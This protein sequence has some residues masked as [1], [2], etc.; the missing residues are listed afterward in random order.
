MF[1]PMFTKNN[2][3]YIDI[4]SIHGSLLCSLC[5]Y[6]F[7]NPVLTKCEPK[8]HMFCHQCI[9]QRIKLDPACPE[10][11]CQQ[12][13]H[14][15]YLTSDTHVNFSNMLDDL[16]VRCLGCEET[17]LKRCDFEAHYNGICP[18]INGACPAADMGCSQRGTSNELD[19]HLKRCIIS[20]VKPTFR[21]FQKYTEESID[22]IKE[23][24]N[25]LET[26]RIDKKQLGKNP[27]TRISSIGPEKADH[28]LNIK[29]NNLQGTI[30]SKIVALL[31]IAK[32]MNME[33]ILNTLDEYPNQFVM[34]PKYD[35]QEEVDNTALQNFIK[36]P[37][38]QLQQSKKN[39]TNDSQSTY[40]K[41]NL[42]NHRMR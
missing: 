39:P 18:K 37:E 4:N 30:S 9:H 34:K 38:I 40:T 27:K 5:K 11:S 28:G 16:L 1:K 6:P 3:E 12:K 2:Y 22:L 32:E 33:K 17:G 15:K 13:I 19:E 20:V 14:S 41:S 42:L 26:S 21:G 36:S 31:Q 7:I 10:P 24:W 8:P 25:L 35:D 29:D 23:L